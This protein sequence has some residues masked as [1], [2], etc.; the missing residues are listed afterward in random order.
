MKLEIDKY[1]LDLEERAN[2]IRRLYSEEEYEEAR[3]YASEFVDNF[4]SSVSKAESFA[5][6]TPYSVSN[7]I[8]VDEREFLK[9]FGITSILL[10]TRT[11]VVRNAITGITRLN[12]SDIDCILQCFQNYV[13]YKQNKK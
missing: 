5:I 4:V 9:I 2:T 11:E 6:G 7:I 3:F 12:L 13:N 10:D 8:K 1:L